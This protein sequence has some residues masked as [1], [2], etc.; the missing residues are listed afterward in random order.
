MARIDVRIEGDSEKLVAELELGYRAADTGA[1][2]TARAKPP[3]SLAIPG[4]T[5]APGARVDYYVRALD[6]HGSVLAESGTPTLPFRLQVAAPIELRREPSRLYQKWWFWTLVGAAAVGAGAI[7]YVE[8]R[9]RTTTTS[10]SSRGRPRNDDAAPSLHRLWV[11]PA[12]AA[13]AACTDDEQ[14]PGIAVSVDLAQFAPDVRTLKVAFS[15]SGG[16]FVAQTPTAT[17][18]CG[19]TTQDIDGDG[20][21]ELVTEFASPGRVDRVPGRDRQPD[22]VDGVGTG[23]GVQ[24][25]PAHRGRRQRCRRHGAAASAAGDRSRSR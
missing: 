6:E 15:A 11:W 9:P 23:D 22:A 4:P 3:V 25:P 20:A 13:A 7:T 5:L 16:G 24:R 14:G 12:A 17:W 2:M 18:A 1:F 19:V 10:W 21:L 8:T